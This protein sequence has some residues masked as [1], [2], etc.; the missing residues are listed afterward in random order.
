MSL[1]ILVLLILLRCKKERD[2][3]S[4]DDGNVYDTVVIGT[5]VWLAENL[6]TTKYNNGTA[7]SL[8]TDNTTWV[9]T[10]TAAYSWYDNDPVNKDVYGALY[11]WYAVDTEL[12]CPV[13]WHV[14]TFDE[15]TTMI[16]Y[17]GG[18]NVA[19]AKLK[20]TGTKYWCSPNDIA[21][22]E[23]GFTARPSGG[24]SHI[25]GTF[26]S[27]GFI[28]SW[29]V[30]SYSENNQDNAY[31]IYIYDNKQGAY[32]IYLNKKTGISVRCIKNN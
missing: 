14:P 6:K 27:I 32:N 10:T 5:Q 3:P 1:I 23:T 31:K 9:A 12:L 11:N 15:W 13:G 24:R 4:D 2:L 29:W 17:L 22:N 16:N 19:G 20:E 18:E 26:G 8:V 21:T 30:S 25:D 28:G 7:I